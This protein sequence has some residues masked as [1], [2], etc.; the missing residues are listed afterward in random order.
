LAATI[1]VAPTQY[2]RVETGKVMPALKTLIKIAKVLDVPLDALVNDSAAP[3]QEVTIKDKTLIDKVR[4][5][6]ELPE[7]EKNM[8]LQVID[9]A[10]SKKKFKDLVQQIG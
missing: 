1:E 3:V 6:D 9:L 7:Q 10:L 4:V 8:I 2:S 5:I